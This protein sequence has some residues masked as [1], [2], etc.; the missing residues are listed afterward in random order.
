[1]KQRTPIYEGIKQ[2]LKRRIETGELKEGDRIPSELEL[3]EQLGVSRSQTRPALRELQLEGYLIRRQGSG[4]FVAPLSNRTPSV[5]VSGTQTVALV[6]PQE[7]YGHANNIVQGFTHR[8]ADQSRQVITYN[9]NIR[10]PD[11]ASE[12]Q[13]LRAVVESGVAGIAAWVVNSDG[14]THEYIQELAERAFPLVLLDRHLPGV[15]TDFVVTDNKKLGYDLTRA[16]LARGHRRIG[17]AGIEY[18]ESSSV[19]ERLAGYRQ[20]IEEASISFD[21]RLVMDIGDMQNAATAVMSLRDEPTAFVCTFEEP[22]DLLAQRLEELGY[23]V[24]EDIEAALVN[25]YPAGLPEVPLIKAPQQGFKI[26][27]TA[28]ELLLARIED[29]GRTTAGRRVSPGELVDTG[30]HQPMQAPAAS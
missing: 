12:V 29:P 10:R 21:D 27:A 30:S 26:G 24:G 23:R 28:A 7:I 18:P 14:Q 17:F 4:S 9:L 20:A 5:R 6:V 16:L 22:L 15:D 19:Q 13:C 2:H 1:V 11:D 8:M 3:A 25:D